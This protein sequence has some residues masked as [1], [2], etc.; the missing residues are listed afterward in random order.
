M[1]DGAL[2]RLYLERRDEADFMEVARRH[3]GLVYST[4]LSCLDDQ[5]A[6]RDVSQAVFVLV[7]RKAAQLTGSKDLAGWLHRAACLKAREHNRA[8]RR[9][10]FRE[11]QCANMTEH[12]ASDGFQERDVWKVCRFRGHSV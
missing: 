2:L 5:E 8:E 6:A 1:N 10:R 12:N 7:A 4:A 3:T 11:Y 9:R